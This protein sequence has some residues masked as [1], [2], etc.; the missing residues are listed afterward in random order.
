[1]LELIDA[2]KA[3]LWKTGVEE[4]GVRRNFGDM[5]C[6]QSGISIRSFVTMSR[7]HAMSA[8]SALQSH[9]GSLAE[10]NSRVHFKQ[11]DGPFAR[12]KMP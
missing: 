3:T 7:A 9:F 2:P 12:R 11:P 8:V 5:K 6:P 4:G 10:V 1:V